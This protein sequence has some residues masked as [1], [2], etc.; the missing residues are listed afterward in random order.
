MGAYLLLSIV[1]FVMV[2]YWAWRNDSVPLNGE[3]TGLFRMRVS[4][5]SEKDV[6]GQGDTA[7]ARPRDHG[8]SNRFLQG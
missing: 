1:A 3:T 8:D 2:A 7:S 4:A 6:E 5:R